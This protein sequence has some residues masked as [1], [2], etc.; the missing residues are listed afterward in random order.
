MDN[1][2]QENRK[3]QARNHRVLSPKER[4]QRE[5]LL[6]KR[7]QVRREQLQRKN[8]G[9][10]EVP[11]DELER[12]NEKQK[13]VQTRKNN[14]GIESFHIVAGILG[15]I[16]FLMAL[17]L[18][19]FVQGIQVKNNNNTAASDIISWATSDTLSFNGLYLWNKINHTKVEYPVS[20]VDAKVSFENPW[21]LTLEVTEKEIVGGVVLTEEYAYFDSEGTVL[22][23]TEQVQVDVIL[24]EGLDVA[25]AVLYEKLPVT[26]EQNFTNTLQVMQLLGKYELLAEEMISGES[27]A[28]SFKMGA[29][30]V[31]LGSEDYES[32]VPHIEPILGELGEVSGSLHLEKFDGTNGT[33]TFK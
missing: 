27:G 28:V 32:K 6:A 4:A 24:V 3:S 12:K 19:T 1:N 7:D 15:M 9:T 16:I 14:Q 25:N 13:V 20:I 21:T 8:R 23:I 17:N 5:Q 22:L 29:I 30:T 2:K 26:N 33:I 31:H 18:L 10:N 11:G